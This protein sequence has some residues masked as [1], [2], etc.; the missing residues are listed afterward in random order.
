MTTSAYPALT[1]AQKIFKQLVWDPGIKA[2]EL[3]FETQVPI[4][5]APV[6]K[7]LEEGVV[8][9]LSDY[10]YSQFVALIDVTAIRLVNAAHQVAYDQASIKLAII[11]HEVGIDSPTFQEARDAAK[12]DLSKFLHIGP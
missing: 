7:A 3:Y 11:A 10:F 2:G 4:F 6:L 1:T 9:E 5:A 8:D 12:L